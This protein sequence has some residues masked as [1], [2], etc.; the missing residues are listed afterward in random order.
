VAQSVD[1]TNDIVRQSK[2]N[3]QRKKECFDAHVKAIMNLGRD[4]AKVKQTHK[5]EKKKC[6]GESYHVPW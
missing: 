6:K 5:E 1:A 2:T 3:T 4:P